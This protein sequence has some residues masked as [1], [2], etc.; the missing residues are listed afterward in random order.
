MEDNRTKALEWWA[1]LTDITKEDWINMECL[2]KE[3]DDVTVKDIE[4]LYNC[5]IRG[6]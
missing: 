4:M 6:E 3:Q 1:K 2:T 5:K